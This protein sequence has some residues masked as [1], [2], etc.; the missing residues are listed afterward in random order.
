MMWV[1]N[2]LGRWTSDDEQWALLP[3]GPRW[4]VMR[5]SGPQPFEWDRL[6]VFPTIDAAK[7]KIR[8]YIVTWHP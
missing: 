1:R 3:V 5:K 6:D 8:D 7:A 4:Q 2:D